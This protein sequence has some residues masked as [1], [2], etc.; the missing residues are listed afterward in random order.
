MSPATWPLNHTMPL[1]ML[2]CD[3][4]RMLLEKVKVVSPGKLKFKTF[5]PAPPSMEPV[6]A[7]PVT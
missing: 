1:L 3:M 6:M 4:F 2:T 7:P 5:V